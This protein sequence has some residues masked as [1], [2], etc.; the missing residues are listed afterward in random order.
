[1]TLQDYYEQR[2]DRDMAL[3]HEE[4]SAYDCN[5]RLRLK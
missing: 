3:L 2:S 5:E 4:Q 1:M